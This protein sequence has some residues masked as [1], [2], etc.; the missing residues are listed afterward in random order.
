MKKIKLFLFLLLFIFI[1]TACE[2]QNI[3]DTS[4]D[5]NCQESSDEQMDSFIENDILYVYY[6][7][8]ADELGVFSEE[9]DDLA[10]FTGDYKVIMPVSYVNV[11]AFIQLKEDVD[12]WY[13]LGANRIDKD[14]KI[15]VPIDVILNKIDEINNSDSSEETT[16]ESNTLEL[17]SDEEYLKLIEEITHEDEKLSDIHNEFALETKGILNDINLL[18]DQIE[19][20]KFTNIKEVS[21]RYISMI[22]CSE[23]VA[24]II[25]NDLS[26]TDFSIYHGSE[27]L[28]TSADDK[29][30]YIYR[31]TNNVEIFKIV[32][33]GTELEVVVE[34]PVQFKN[35]DNKEYIL[36]S[37]RFDNDRPDEVILGYV[38][39]NSDE[40]KEFFQY[41]NNMYYVD[42]YISPDNIMLIDKDGTKCD[43]SV[44]DQSQT[45]YMPF[46][47]KVSRGDFPMYM[48]ISGKANTFNF[49]SDHYDRAVSVGSNYFFAGMNFM[50]GYNALVDWQIPEKFTLYYGQYNQLY[51]NEGSGINGFGSVLYNDANTTVFA[52]DIVLDTQKYDTFSLSYGYLK[53]Y[54]NIYAA[55]EGEIFL[56][57]QANY[58]SEL[59]TALGPLDYDEC[60]VFII[61]T[62]R[63]V[64]TNPSMGK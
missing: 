41:D 11:D 16:I 5:E 47:I 63:R 34:R 32:S 53:D 42:S 22:P 51:Y 31:T 6:K 36:S 23:G 17:Y 14:E 44:Q 49:A 20:L 19:L 9:G 60:G 52:G 64:F 46:R 1:A 7:D 18:N 61:P 21:F 39:E 62:I 40:F 57:E 38:F 28:F 35:K 37:F 56:K 50:P 26:D 13:P 24:I 8:I 3:E 25:N 55:K 33:L 59:I 15:Y 10:F 29:A 4:N 45:N 48:V 54:E 58:L 30:I 12:T 27:L 2:Y 43:V